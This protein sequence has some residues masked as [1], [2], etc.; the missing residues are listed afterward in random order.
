MLLLLS[1]LD[2]LRKIYTPNDAGRQR[3]NFMKKNNVLTK[4]CRFFLKERFDAWPLTFVKKLTFI[5]TVRLSTLVCG[6]LRKRNA[7]F[8]RA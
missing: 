5:R 1:Y 3:Y 2:F 7:D 6:L 4:N 8:R